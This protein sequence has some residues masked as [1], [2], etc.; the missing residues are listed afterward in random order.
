[1]SKNQSVP[2]AELRRRVLRDKGVKPAP[3]TKKMLTL[4]EQPDAFPK[5]SKMKVLEYKYHIK[6][7]VVLFD[8]SLDEVVKFFHSDIDRSTVSKWRKKYS[9]YMEDKKF[10]AQF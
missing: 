4:H 9:C 5:T 2:L 10:H 3:G 7:E 1:M 8:G 6:I